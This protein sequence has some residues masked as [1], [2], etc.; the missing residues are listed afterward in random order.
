MM[1][2]ALFALA[3]S[4]TAFQAVAT[5]PAA[6]S[7]GVVGQKIDSGVGNLP[8]YRS[9][10]DK[11]GKNVVETRVAGEKIDSGLGDI[12]PFSLGRNGLPKSVDLASNR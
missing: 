4:L 6:S 11:S 3:T 9:W 5:E 2:I 8:H 12:A 7:H 10:A 1:K